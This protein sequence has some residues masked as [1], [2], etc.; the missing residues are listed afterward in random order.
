MKVSNKSDVDN[1]KSI[2]QLINNMIKNRTA[3]K[4]YFLAYHYFFISALW[5]IMIRE[6]AKEA[7]THTDVY[8]D[9][10]GVMD[11]IILLV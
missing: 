10:F 8:D 6:K 7:Y 9:D 3:E 1:A 4:Q 5:L 2:M 11:V